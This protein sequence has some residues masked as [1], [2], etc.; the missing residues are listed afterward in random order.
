MSITFTSVL[1][2][3]VLSVFTPDVICLGFMASFDISLG[4]KSL[5]VCGCAMRDQAWLAKSNPLGLFSSF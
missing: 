1:K 5:I 2:I 3:F 4:G